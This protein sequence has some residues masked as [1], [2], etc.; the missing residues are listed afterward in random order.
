LSLSFLF[1]VENV[2]D[3]GGCFGGE[4]CTSCERGFPDGVENK[5]LV[6]V[7]R[8]RRLVAIGSSGF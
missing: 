3:S 5:E 7:L 6:A 4:A 2:V 8:V 1:G